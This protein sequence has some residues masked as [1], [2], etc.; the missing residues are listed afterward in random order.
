MEIAGK[1]AVGVVLVA[2]LVW[3]VSCRVGFYQECRAHGGSGLYC[4]HIAS[5]R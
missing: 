4:A 5:A 3:S 1:I 2:I